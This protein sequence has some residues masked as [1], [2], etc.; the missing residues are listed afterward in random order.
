[1]ATLSVIANI[2]D[3]ALNPGKLLKQ[4]LR[5]NHM[6]AYAAELFTR[7]PKYSS[8]NNLNNIARTSCYLGFKL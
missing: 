4:S 6:T 8:K 1:M 7:W 3:A 2:D 5:A